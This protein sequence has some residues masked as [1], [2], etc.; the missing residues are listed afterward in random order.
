MLFRPAVTFLLLWSDRTQAKSARVRLAP[1]PCL[2]ALLLQAY[3]RILISVFPEE[4]Y[5]N[6]FR[7]LGDLGVIDLV[8]SEVCAV[9]GW[10][11]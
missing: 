7:K 9:G 4:A 8:P 11:L 5:T 3:Q 1:L 10:A 2:S 6:F